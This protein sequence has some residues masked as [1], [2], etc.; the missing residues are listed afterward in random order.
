MTF[1]K[2]K[3]KDEKWL[4]EMGHPNEQGHKLIAKYINE[5]IKNENI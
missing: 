3:N 4:K 2:S 1:T 5:V